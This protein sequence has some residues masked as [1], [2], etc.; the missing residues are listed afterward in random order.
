MFLFKCKMLQILIQF[1]GVAGCHIEVTV[2][3]VKKETRTQQCKV[4]TIKVLREVD[5]GI[6]L[7]SIPLFLHGE[8]KCEI[9]KLNAF[10]S[11]TSLCLLFFSLT[12]DFQADS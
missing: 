12:G 4:I 10:I 5:E 1:V 2:K 3:K 9:L 7:V 8:A 11:L 6:Y